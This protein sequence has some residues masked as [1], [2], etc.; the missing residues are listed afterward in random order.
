MPN[1]P[2]ERVATD[3]F[4]FI[5][6]RRFLKID[7]AMLEHLPPSLTALN[8]NG[9]Q[10]VAQ[11]FS[12]CWDTSAILS[13]CDGIAFTLPPICAL[14]LPKFDRLITDEKTDSAITSLL[15]VPGQSPGESAELGVS[16]C[17][18]SGVVPMRSATRA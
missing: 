11:P 13:Y 3:L 5:R 7:D 6:V 15:R 12:F 4:A 1:R 17:C 14:P 2:S 16:R 9:C 10:E 8:L 18:P